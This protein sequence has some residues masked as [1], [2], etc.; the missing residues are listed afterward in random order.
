MNNTTTILQN[1]STPETSQSE[2]ERFCLE[3][4]FRAPG[5]HCAPEEDRKSEI[6]DQKQQT[7]SYEPINQQENKENEEELIN[8]ND[9]NQVQTNKCLTSNDDEI[10]IE[11]KNK[12]YGEKWSDLPYMNPKDYG[13]RLCNS[14]ELKLFKQDKQDLVERVCCTNSCC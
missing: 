5:L 11:D 3:D 7:S 6:K 4:F 8:Q 9:E 1:Q 14:I 12:G 10:K 13:Y 2:I